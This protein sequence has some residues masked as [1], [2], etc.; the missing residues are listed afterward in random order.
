MKK[1][2]V[3]ALALAVVSLIGC[4]PKKTT[5]ETT[6]GKDSTKIETPAPDTTKKVV[7]TT[8]KAEP[9]TEKKK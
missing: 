9:V 5:T 8:K 2:F 6:E 7:D 4:K 1:V 3:L